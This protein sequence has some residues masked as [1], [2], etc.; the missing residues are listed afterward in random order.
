MMLPTIG[1]LRDRF[2]PGLSS[3]DPADKARSGLL[4]AMPLDEALASPFESDAHFVCYQPR[5]FTDAWPRCNR[6]VLGQ[7]RAS[8]TDLVT[9]LLTLDYD[10]PGHAHWR[11]GAWLAWLAR[12]ESLARSGFD[13]AMRWSAAYATRGGARLIYVLREPV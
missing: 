8:G 6:S 4:A 10:N 11:E 12:L 7:L 3:L 1:I 9:A 5:P 2:T 13:L